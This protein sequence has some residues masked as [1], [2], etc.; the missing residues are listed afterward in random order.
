MGISA[1]LGTT[2]THLPPP[3]SLG[4]GSPDQSQFTP[5]VQQQQQP[6]P[7]QQQQPQQPPPPQ[8]TSPSM[9]GIPNRNSTSN[10]YRPLNVKDALSYL[11]QVKVQFS[12]QAEVYNNFLDIMKDF[13]SQRYVSKEFL[14]FFVFSPSIIV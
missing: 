12:N 11:D 14:H 13:K 3:S 7:P 6:P 4:H 8:Q 2:S 5:T 9:G 1:P 10:V